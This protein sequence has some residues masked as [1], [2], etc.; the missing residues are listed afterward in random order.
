MKG[1]PG[2]TG[3]PGNTGER[4][5]RGTAGPPGM[6]GPPGSI[7]KPG[8]PGLQGIPGEQGPSGP[9]GSKGHRGLI[10]LQGLPGP[11]GPPGERGMPGENGKNGEP[12]APGSRGPPGLDGQAGMMGNPGP[13]GPR[14]LQGEEGKRGPPGELGAPGPPGPPGEGSG[15]D[16][17][18]LSAMMGQGSSKGPD[19]MSGDEP[20]RVYTT[21]EQEELMKE[22][23]EKLKLSFDKMVK[24]DGTQ[25]RP[26]KSCKDLKA[27]HPLKASGDY[28]IDPNGNDHRDSILVFCDMSTGATCINPKPSLSPILNIISN[29]REMWLG[30]AEEVNFDINYKAD[31]N[32]VDHLQLLSSKAEQTITF[33]CRNMVAFLNLRNQPRNAVSFMA[34]NDLEIRHR[35]KSKYKVLKDD[36]KFKKNSWA[37]TTFSI[38]TAKPARLPITDIK[39]E[40]FGEQNQEFKLELGQVCFS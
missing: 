39:L 4:G 25:A 36:C 9:K 28:W 30:D 15:F 32:Q 38:E 7:G 6:M 8:P 27:T 12:G 17:A 26:A 33:H 2:K 29:E 11:I 35:G 23:F 24:A 13:V 20:A 5:E 40:D 18:A 1:S 21:P 10:G 34:W 14:G 37:Q 16:M 3:P 22:A 31:S 19:P